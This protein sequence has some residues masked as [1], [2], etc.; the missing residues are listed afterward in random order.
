MTET[1]DDRP[2]LGEISESGVD[3]YKPLSGLAV[4]AFVFG[5]LA[6]LAFVGPLL[7]IF[8]LTGILLSV[9]ALARIGTD[10]PALTGRKLALAGLVLSTL[11]LSIAPSYRLMS[12]H[13]HRN[14]ARQFASA[15]FGFLANDQPQMAHQLTEPP[16][17]RRVLDER[18]WDVYA[19]DYELAGKLN[20]FTTNAAVRALLELGN[21]AR[22]R[23]YET[24]LQYPERGTERIDLL[25]A[26]TFEEKGV[27]KTF[28]VSLKMLRAA[29]AGD[30][31][32]GWRVSDTR[33]K[34]LP[35]GMSG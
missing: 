23:F 34:S 17:S 12:R 26:V 24:Q 14:E 27:K 19:E 9:V 3:E 4:V 11:C 33:D 29:D 8:G 30:G 32:A 16:H 15:W 7:Y 21:G 25:Y 18:L 35:A 20:I 31:R 13:L 2:R 1:L 5:L 6:P 22:I 28:F 10:S